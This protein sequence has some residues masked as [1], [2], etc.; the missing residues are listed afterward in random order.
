MAETKS[1]CCIVTG[2][3]GGIGQA[4]VRELDAA[5]FAVIATDNAAPCV[6]LPCRYF[7]CVDLARTVEDPSEA[8]RVFSEIRSHLDGRPLAALINNAAVQIIGDVETLGR[9]DWRRTLDVNLL[10][11]F[12]WTQALLSELEAAHGCVV[13]IGSIH[14]RL[15]KRRFAAY[16]T[17]K[18]ALAALTRSLAIELGGRIRV[19]AIEPAAIDTPML[20]AGFADDPVGLKVLKAY[21]PCGAIGSPEALGCLV[22]MLVEQESVFA[23]GTVL[24]FDGGI[25]AC[26]H[27]PDLL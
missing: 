11:P 10:A 17:S 5:G 21:H 7:V 25:S 27:D 24:N 8:E 13:N 3:C 18:A 9:K 15:T 6:D 1:R 22:R 16:A 14:A 2:A 23:N 12:F 20:R 26:L 19:N 4:L